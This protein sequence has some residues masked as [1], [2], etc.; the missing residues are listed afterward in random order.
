MFKLSGNLLL[1]ITKMREFHRGGLDENP[2]G[3]FAQEGRLAEGREK[4]LKYTFPG[5]V[6]I[7]PLCLAN[8]RAP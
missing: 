7:S 2:R 5:E 1:L 4:E 8:G 3:Q 6:E